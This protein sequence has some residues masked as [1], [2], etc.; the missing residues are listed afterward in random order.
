MGHDLKQPVST[1]HMCL[2]LLAPQLTSAEDKETLG[3]AKTAIDTLSTE[4]DLLAEASR[5]DQESIRIVSLPIQRV[6]D[7]I[8]EN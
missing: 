7:S 6:L 1:I 4:L 8:R 5:L 2:S 3:Y